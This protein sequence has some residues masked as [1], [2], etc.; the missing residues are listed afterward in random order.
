MAHGLCAIAPGMRE[1]CWITSE[2][3]DLTAEE[4]EEILRVWST[5]VRPEGM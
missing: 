4:A 2:L 3:G 1:T 5:S